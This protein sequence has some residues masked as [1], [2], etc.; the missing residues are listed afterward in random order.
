LYNSVKV[1]HN[2]SLGPTSNGREG[3]GRG[4]DGREGRG[5]G[6]DGRAGGPLL[7]VCCPLPLVKKARSATDQ[8]II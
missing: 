4:R 6:G 7:S 3:E 8:N 5:R 1:K 2:V